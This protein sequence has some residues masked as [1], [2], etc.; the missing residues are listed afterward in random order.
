MRI[1]LADTGC[2]M[3]M[4]TR[5]RIYE[6]FFT[7]KKDSGTGLG[8]WVTSE[9]IDR[10]H[11]DLRVWSSQTPGRSG[12]VFS[13]FLPTLESSLGIKGPAIPHEKTLQMN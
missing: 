2:G 1:T 6:P 12:T 7:T 10:Q 8:L 4:Q 5:R 11:G 9:I 13:L 3:D